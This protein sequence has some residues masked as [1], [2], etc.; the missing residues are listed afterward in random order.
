MP[1]L[2]LLPSRVKAKRA[3][4][5]APRVRNPAPSACPSPP[6]RHTSSAAT[7]PTVLGTTPTLHTNHASQSFRR[8]EDRENAVVF[9]ILAHSWRARRR[10]HRSCLLLACPC[11]PKSV[12][13]CPSIPI[14]SGATLKPAFGDPSPT[15]ATALTCDHPTAAD[16]LH[17]PVHTMYAMGSPLGLFLSP[18]GAGLGTLPHVFPPTGAGA[19][20]F[21]CSLCACVR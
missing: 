4:S 19:K 14:R 12:Q 6:K 5:G 1:V 7:I 13:P 3:H 17:F 9:T 2:L 20:V 10:R 11:S 8:T 15:P 18:R 16:A 21:A